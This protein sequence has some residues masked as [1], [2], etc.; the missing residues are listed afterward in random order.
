LDRLHQQALAHHTAGDL[1]KAAGLY[2]RILKTW[3]QVVEVQRLLAIIDLQQGR[4]GDA[5]PVLEQAIA[6]DPF[7]HAWHV[8][9]GNALL[10]A[11]RH[12]DAVRA[13]NH[14]LRCMTEAVPDGERARAY[15]GLGRALA[16][17][18]N[19]PAAVAALDQAVTLAPDYA[20]AWVWLG[21]A[22]EEPAANR[23]PVPAFAEAVRLEP[24]NPS[25]ATA[26]GIGQMLR[27]LYAEAAAT[28]DRSLALKADQPL[29]L[30]WRAR[31]FQ[32]DDEPGLRAYQARLQA[33]ADSLSRQ[34]PTADHQTTADDLARDRAQVAFAL[35][36]CCERLGE[37]KAGW[38][39]LVTANRIEAGRAPY[40]GR[41]QRRDME[42]IER[43]FT[44][45]LFARR[46]A[47]GLRQSPDAAPVFIV[48]LPRS[49][50]SL[51]EQILATHP[52]MVGIGECT[53]LEALVRAPDREA[54]LALPPGFTW[55]AAVADLPD[56]AFA[57]MGQAYMDRATALTPPDKRIIDK[58]PDN[59]WQ[60]GMIRL[61]LPDAVIIHCR[62]DLMDVGLSLF[63]QLFNGGLEYSYDL[64]A[65]GRHINM[66]RRLM[67]HWGRVLPP[68]DDGRPAIHHMDYGRLLADQEAESRD[69][70][71]CCSLDWDPAVLDFHK[72]ERT[73]ATASAGQVRRPLDRAGEG[74]WRRHEAG[75]RP[76]ARV[77]ASGALPGDPPATET[78]VTGA[79]ITK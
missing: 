68:R 1:D 38:D 67:D 79:A 70:L 43:V 48:G 47:A 15:A 41:P 77:L 31:L 22:L 55:P 4:Y 45:D 36:E 65:M 50:T 8:N 16:L 20:Q 9:L 42:D 21:Q 46:A 17:A 75:L 78:P 23:D 71:A 56:A 7:N 33:Q 76:L 74:G 61:M 63:R 25:F 37:D 27:G 18:A 3:P 10:G 12:R 53:F 34:R 40:D 60:I 14:G 51:T 35:A 64:E 39:H 13:F 29:A 30:H 54:G 6:A 28:L 59:Y 11:R 26:L 66:Y 49:A 73:V 58:M 57:A 44:A 24:A 19:T 32:R 2:R 62:R 52:A 69:L 72:T 5:I